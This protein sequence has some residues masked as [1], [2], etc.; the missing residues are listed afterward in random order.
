M[1]REKGM[2]T[3]VVQKMALAQ[4]LETEAILDMVTEHRVTMAKVVM[5]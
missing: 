3:Q 5:I 2:E 1:E 4:E